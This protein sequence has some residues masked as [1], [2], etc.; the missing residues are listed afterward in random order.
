MSDQSQ[1]DYSFKW[2]LAKSRKGRK[3]Q[4]TSNL[5]D[6]TRLANRYREALEHNDK[7]SLPLIAFY[8]TERVVLD[9]PLKIKT[10]HTFLAIGRVR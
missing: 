8:P 7:A 3:A 1:N 5:N 9:I 2:A 4:Y 10:K 6:C